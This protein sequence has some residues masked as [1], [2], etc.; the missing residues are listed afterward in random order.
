[1]DLGVALDLGGPGPVHERIAGVRPILEAAAHHG[2]DSVWVGESYQGW[3]VARH[4]PSSLVVLAHLAALTT[5]G[6]GTGVLLARTYPPARLLHDAVMVNELSQGRLTLGLGLGN[7]ANQRLAGWAP[8]RGGELFDEALRRLAGGRGV[9]PI[10]VGGA[11]ERAIERAV[12]FGDGYYAATNYSDDLLRV[13]AERYR[14]GAAGRAGT[15]AVNRLCLLDDDRE[16][17]RRHA[18]GYLDPVRETYVGLRAW[19][20]GRDPAAAT[21]PPVLVGT[22]EDVASRLARYASWGVTRVNL[23]IASLGTPL[24]VSLRTLALAGRLAA[25]PG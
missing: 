9:P 17:A 3:G 15:V 25:Q 20:V 18:R 1:M 16:R 2:L 13:Q 21:G 23:R 19:D 8:R 4:R 6:L 22:P 10:L 12:E 5:L 11:G 24:E 14:L 7:L